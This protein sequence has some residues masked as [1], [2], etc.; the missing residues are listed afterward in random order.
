MGTISKTISR[1]GVVGIS[2]RLTAS[3]LGQTNPAIATIALP[4]EQVSREFAQ[5][6]W[7]K[8]DGLP[9]NEVQSLLQT[10]DGFLWIGT[11]RGLVRFD[12]MKFLVFD[13][14]N[15]PAIVNDDCLSLTEDLKGNLWIATGDGLLRFRN[16][17][18]MRYTRKDGLAYQVGEVKDRTPFIYADRRGRVWVKT[19]FLDSIEA[20]SLRH[21][22]REEGLEH[23][24]LTALH[25]D[26]SGT[27]WAAGSGYCYRFNEED[28]RFEV[29]PDSQRQRITP[30]AMAN[31]FCGG[32]W[33]LCDL[34]KRGVW[35][36]RFR[37]SHWEPYWRFAAGSQNYFLNI[38]RNGDMWTATLY[39]GL[40]RFHEGI[41]TRY[42]FPKDPS[43][44]RA[45]CFRADPEGNLWFGTELGGLHCWKPRAFSAHNVGDGQADDNTWTICEAR[46]GS[47]WIG[48]ENGLSHFKDGRF[49][50]FTKSDG[51]AGDKVRS[52][53]E[54]A[55][56]SIWVGTSSGLSVIRDGVAKPFEFPHAQEK[57]KTRVVLPATDGT[58]WLGTVEGLFRYHDGAWATYRTT[59]GLA[60]N[61]VR[62][63][64]EDHA[65]NLWVGTA[66]GGFQ[67]YCDGK[68]TTWTTTNGVS[69]NSVWAFHADKDGVLWV[70]TESGLNRFVGDKFTVFTT[71]EGLPADLVNEILEDDFGNLWVSHDHGIYRVRKQELDDVAVG[72][73]TQVQAVSYDETD[74]LP[75]NETN[76]QKSYPAGC[77]TRDGRLWFPT[78]KGVTVIDPKMCVR[79]A[80]APQAVVEQVRVDGEV[81]HDRTA[82]PATA[83][84]AARP[85]NANPQNEVNSPGATPEPLCLPPGSGR[86]LEFRFTA[87]VFTAPEK[88]S[89]RYRLRGLDDRW[90][91]AGTRRDAFFTRLHPGDYEFQ[92]RA[93]DHHGVWGETGG[94]FS[95]RITPFFYQKGWFIVGCI[96]CGCSAIITLVLWRIRSLRQRH[97]LQQ[98]AAIAE[99]RAR[100]AKDLHD[101]LGADLT[102][103]TMLAD[104]ASGEANA[105]GAEHARKLS[106]TSRSATR[107][108]KEMIWIANPAN[109]S[110]TGLVSRLAQNAEEFLSDAGIKCRLELAPN[111][112]KHPLSLEQRRN[113]LLVTREA[114]NNIFKH[115]GATVVR[116][117]AS[118]SDDELELE[119]E[120]NG[121]GFDLNAARPDGL[122]LNS[123]RERVDNLGGRFVLESQPGLGTKMMIRLKLRHG[124]GDFKKHS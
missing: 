27:L 30:V 117:R 109:D 15:T 98:G 114:L 19:L 26:S 79:D 88:A 37:Q 103:L 28:R 14:L 91:E 116:L 63:L 118:A 65:G 51:L 17:E 84:R 124:T 45:R 69:N 121:R 1:L 41:F 122:G 44:D 76:G 82:P 40:D 33:S 104:L 83:A 50:N 107:E 101:G 22:G 12:G 94:I 7:K 73:V 29:E 123:M 59:N 55:E 68:F 9:D 16:G 52:V 95:F 85:K 106:Q 11:R 48:T 108:L 90:I 35:I 58:L 43:S 92:V 120:D 46:D 24:G 105:P 119:I 61:D 111:L 20:G 74:G 86:V 36:Y 67:R 70:G 99:E 39:G 113:L 34:G 32:L 8:Q 25:E 77:R 93:A 10:R 47:V 110:V 5:R 60:N 102:R 80:V 112:P 57:D 49:H 53:A 31:D 71:R 4:A 100:I 72:R 78:T 75:S 54:D 56:G 97:Q 62:A 21:F 66:G 13:H 81:V 87:P 23:P 18:F 38:D 96:L 89:F 6:S 2:L 42:S 115:A 3:S 64:C